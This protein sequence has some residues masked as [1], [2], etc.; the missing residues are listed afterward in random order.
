[1]Q[2]IA[3][4]RSEKMAKEIIIER[5]AMNSKLKEKDFEIEKKGRSFMV[6]L[7]K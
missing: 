5:K 7:K 6:Y 4:T 3:I 1:M 2:R